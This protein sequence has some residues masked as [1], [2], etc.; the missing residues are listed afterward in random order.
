MSAHFK[1]SRIPTICLLWRPA[2]VLLDNRISDLTV[3]TA[4]NKLA[5]VID[6]EVDRLFILLLERL[7]PAL[8]VERRKR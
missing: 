7:K 1:S 5:L 6:L 3:F 2:I 4:E 8:E